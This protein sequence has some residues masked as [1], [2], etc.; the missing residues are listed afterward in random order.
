MRNWKWLV[1]DIGLALSLIVIFFVVRYS[2]ING[3][4][5]IPLHKIKADYACKYSRFIE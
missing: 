5:F 3:G 1:E 4:R 2:I